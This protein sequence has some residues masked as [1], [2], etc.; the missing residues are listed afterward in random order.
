MA[1]QLCERTAMDRSLPVS[2]LRSSRNYDFTPE[3]TARMHD[4]TC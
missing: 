1:I 3:E 2:M 4:A